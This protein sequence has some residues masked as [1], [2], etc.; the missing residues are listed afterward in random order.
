MKS[1]QG[2]DLDDYLS[3]SFARSESHRSHIRNVYKDS[4]DRFLP[5][6][7]ENIDLKITVGET[8][9][10]EQQDFLVWWDQKLLLFIEVVGITGSIVNWRSGRLTTKVCLYCYIFKIID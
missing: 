2:I 8:K 7:N 1:K 3:Q 9:K 5:D 6:R 10:K 4:V